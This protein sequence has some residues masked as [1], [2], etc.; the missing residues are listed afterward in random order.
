MHQAN[1]TTASTTDAI[2]GLVLCGG[3]GSRMGGVDKGLQPYLGQPLA[4]HA[5]RRLQAQVGRCW[6][7]ANRNLAQYAA[8]GVPVCTDKQSSVSAQLGDYPGPLAG[9][10]AALEQCPT[11]YLMTVPCDSPLFPTDLVQR[12][13][14]AMAAE[15][16]DLALAAT[17]EAGAAQTQPVFCLM[18]TRLAP[19]LAD[20]LLAGQRKIDRW[21]AG[22]RQAVV[23]FEDAGAFFNANT[24]ED[25]A[26]LHSSDPQ[27]G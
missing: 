18:R 9:W 13:V 15:D 11:P 14:D 21:T 7:N 4:A 3:R 23:L 27:A 17:I 10:L 20:F 8:L 16:A 19:S 12:L 1:A 5:L 6:I 2:T 22:Q 25:L 26:A 24:L